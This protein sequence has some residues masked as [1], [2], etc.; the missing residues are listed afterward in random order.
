MAVSSG[1]LRT[2]GDEQR[3]MGKRELLV[4][5]R[6]EGWLALIKKT[7]EKQLDFSLIAWNSSRLPSGA[8]Q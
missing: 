4:S 8:V 6:K 2:A 1:Q 5:L 7:L 3:A